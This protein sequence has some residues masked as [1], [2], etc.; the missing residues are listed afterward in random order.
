MV[1]FS[2]PHC[3]DEIYI[4]GKDEQDV[5]DPCIGIVCPSCGKCSEDSTERQYEMDLD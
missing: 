1:S 4:R 2:C 5:F 3:G